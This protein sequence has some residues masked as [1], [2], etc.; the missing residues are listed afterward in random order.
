MPPGTPPSRRGHGRARGSLGGRTPFRSLHQGP[1]QRAG[2][3]ATHAPL[4]MGAPRTGGGQWGQWRV[5]V[6]THVCRACSVGGARAWKGRWG[7]EA[8]NTRWSVC[9]WGRNG[10]KERVMGREGGQGG[11][12]CGS[13]GHREGARPFPH[14]TAGDRRT[15]YEPTLVLGAISGAPRDVTT[16][17]SSR[18]RLATGARGGRGAAAPLV[19]TTV[20]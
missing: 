13:S 20:M 3:P 16:D 11:R 5:V 14:T 2:P 15:P 9:V 19:T 4:H 10:W 17:G 8:C 18:R 12:G 1:R 7:S 6:A